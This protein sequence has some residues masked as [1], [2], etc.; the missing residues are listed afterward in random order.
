MGQKQN[1]PKKKTPDHPQ[2]ELS[3]SHMWPELGSNPQRQDDGD[4]ER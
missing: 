1:I 2:A 4:L 3:L